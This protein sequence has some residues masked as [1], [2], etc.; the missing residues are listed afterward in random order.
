VAVFYICALG[1]DDIFCRLFQELTFPGMFRKQNICSACGSKL[2]VGFG[3]RRNYELWSLYDVFFVINY[4][5]G[6][7]V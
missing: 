5:N 3:V 1:Y 4:I 7:Y 6:G 2:G